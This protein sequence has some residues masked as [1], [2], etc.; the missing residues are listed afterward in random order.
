MCLTHIHFVVSVSQYITYLMA[1]NHRQIKR[2]KRRRSCY[3]TF[4]FFTYY[5]V[6]FTFNCGTCHIQLKFYTT[7]PL[8]FKSFI[9]VLII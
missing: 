1:L 6:F 8:N 3:T 5:E 2:F 9:T 7:F 4:I